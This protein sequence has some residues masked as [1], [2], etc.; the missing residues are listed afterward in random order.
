MKSSKEPRFSAPKVPI[1]LP[2]ST[3][4]GTSDSVAFFEIQSDKWLTTEEA[5][6]YLRISPKS[7]LN[8]A[9]NGNIPHYKFGRRNRYLL[10]ELKKLLLGKPRGVLHGN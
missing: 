2:E 9:S 6:E 4:R 1:D 7:L 3:A 5:A 8:E 10:S